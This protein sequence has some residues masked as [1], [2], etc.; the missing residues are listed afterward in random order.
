MRVT[1]SGR[2]PISEVILIAG[3]RAPSV[4]WF[5][6][7]QRDRP[8]CCIDR[9]IDFCR[10]NKIVPV[11]LIGDFDSAANDS[12]DWA[13][14][15][16]VQIERHPVDKD[17][18]DTQLSLNQVNDDTFAIITGAFGGRFD[19]LYS[20][21]FTCAN[22][23]IKNCLADESEA[24]FF[25]SSVENMSIKLLQKPLALSLLPMT[26]VCEGVSIDGVHWP[27]DLADLKQTL[28]NAISNRVEEDCV[29]VSIEKGI[30]AVYFC[31]AE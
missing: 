16:G 24:I 10:D 23:Q 13:I 5:K 7:L 6:A 8:I 21:I 15:H 20:T 19:H 31:F 14:R 22:A 25:I 3:G 28:P 9:G 2:Q 27:L 29:N 1:F 26:E 30:L 18:T 4:E 12:V 11:S 17:F